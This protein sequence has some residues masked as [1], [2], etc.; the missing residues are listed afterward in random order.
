ML[1]IGVIYNPTADVFLSGLNQTAI[2][3]AELFHKLDYKV[4][5]ISNKQT[6]NLWWD[7]LPKLDVELY[8]IYDQNNVDIL[9]DI[10]GYVNPSYRK[11]IAKQ[12]IVFLRTF[13]QFMELDN[14]VYPERPYLPRSFDG[15]SSIWCWDILNPEETIPS[16]QT[17]FP[18]PIYRVPFIWSSTVASNYKTLT[19]KYNSDSGWNIHIAEKN[20]DETSSNIIPLVAIRELFLKNTINAKYKAHN[21]EHIRENK[22][23]VENILNN[24]EINK[25]PVEFVN[26]M[27]FY[28]WTDEENP[29]LFSHSRFIPLRIGLLN[30]IW[31]GLP[32]IHNS[33]ILKDLHPNLEKMYYFGNEITGIIHVFKTFTSNLKSYLDDIDEIRNS[34]LEI[35]GI[36]NNLSKWKSIFSNITTMINVSENTKDNTKTNTS[37]EN[38]IIAFSDMWPGFN[39][40]SNFFIDAVRN[41]ISKEGGQINGVKYSPEIKPNL[42]IFGPYSNDWKNIPDSIPKIFFSG[43]NWGVPNDPCIKL[44]L[45]SSREEDDTH[46][47]IPIWMLFIDWFSKLNTI[48]DDSTDNPICIPLHFATTPHLISFDERKDFCAFVVSNPFCQF[49][50]DTFMALSSYKK[51]NSGGALFNNIDGQLALKYPGGGSGDISKYNFFTKHKFTIS[52][53]NS[54]SSGYITEK[55]L[56][57]K[58][59]GCIPL[60]WGD[61]HTDSDFTPGSIVNLSQCTDVEQ[62]VN[63]VKKLEENPELCKKIASTPILNEEKLLKAQNTISKM[64][65]KLLTLCSNVSDNLPNRIEKIYVMNLDERKDRWNNLLN[66]EPYLANKITRISAINGRNLQMNNDI[67]KLFKNNIFNWKKSI[68]GCFL[69]HINIWKRIINESGEYFMILEDDVRFVNGWLKEWNT[70]SKHIPDDAEL[71]YLGGVLPPNKPMLNSCLEHVNESWSKIKP[72][73][74]FSSVNTPIFH[75][76]AYSYIISKNAAKKLLDFLNTSEQKA[77]C[78][79]DHF[80]MNPILNLNKYVANSLLTHCFQDNDPIYQTAQFNNVHLVEEYDSDI[81]NNTDCF[82]Q[83]DLLNFNVDNNLLDNVNIYYLVE[84][85]SQLFEHKWISE[86]FSE[87]TLKPLAKYEDVKPNS[88][89]LVQRP[90]ADKWNVLFKQFATN[91][92][93]FRVLHLSDEFGNDCIEFYRYSTCRGVIRNY[94]RPD[95]P[96]LPHILTIPLGFHYKGI[97]NK[98]FLER[99]LVW[100]FHGTKWFNR[101]L[102]LAELE[103]LTPHICHFTDEWNSPQMTKE[104]KYISDLGNSQFCPIPRGNNYETFRLYEALESGSIPIYVRYAGDNEFWNQITKKLKLVNLDSWEKAREFIMFLK[105]RPEDAE[106]YRMTILE[107]W[108]NWKNEIKSACRRLL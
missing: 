93:D 73:T 3:L 18:C 66:A 69:S 28:K 42:L 20:T 101:D 63:I 64:A 79:A 92:I 68:M 89:F 98:K 75:F 80:I 71:L 60:Y 65:S 23:L 21:M 81:M 31:L 29:V 13:V 74:L 54:Q 57:S 48:P 105:D 55:P 19:P 94:L 49:R 84:P 85:N 16:I 50:N 104:D 78:P 56:H 15:V 103:S 108:L 25:L 46:L 17:L 51:V 53:E 45:T 4:S 76:C 88:W 95:C 67:Y 61:S 44:Y 22:F 40:D 26:K 7:E 10:D 102:D 5:L 39:Y 6:D 91:N 52:F 59:A 107:N 24:I 11:K 87:Y 100:N 36:D 32:V 96:N 30:A 62:I 70:F 43:E 83:D 35:W 27:P 2:C 33:P 58:M 37:F 12:T 106:K 47:R 86:I 34:I 90:H 14:S 41:E 97:N 38:V 8:T 72:N 1:H 77:F 99:K 82:T 9:I